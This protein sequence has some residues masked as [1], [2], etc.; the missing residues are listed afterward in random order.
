M[1]ELG[2]VYNATMHALGEVMPLVVILG[3]VV[4]LVAV[5]RGDWR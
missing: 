5:M 1:R 4:L 2:I 3:T